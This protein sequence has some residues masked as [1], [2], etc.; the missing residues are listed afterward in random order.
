VG[1][2]A[3][4]TSPILNTFYG[5]T[6]TFTSITEQSLGGNMDYSQF[7]N[8]KWNW[9]SVTDLTEENHIFNKIFRENITLAPLEIRTF[10]FKDLKF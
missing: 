9:Q 2:F 6:T 10:L 7:L 8:S 3:N 1:V 4:K 5:R